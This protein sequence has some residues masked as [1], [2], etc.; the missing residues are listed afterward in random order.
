METAAAASKPVST[1]FILTSTFG[2]RR[3]ARGVGDVCDCGLLFGSAPDVV[4]DASDSGDGGM[5]DS[6]LFR[7]GD[8]TNCRLGR[9]SEE[10]TFELQSLLRISYAV[11]CLKTKI[12][13]A[14]N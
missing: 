3:S 9:R 10:H 11:F 14:T 12:M 4:H 7:T 6:D 13:S 2:R 1:L 8:E 5:S